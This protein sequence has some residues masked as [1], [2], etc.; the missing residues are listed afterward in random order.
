MR[1]TKQKRKGCED[2]ENIP[3]LK[4]LAESIFHNVHF[5]DNVYKEF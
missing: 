5:L 2:G 3:E 1:K 4:Q